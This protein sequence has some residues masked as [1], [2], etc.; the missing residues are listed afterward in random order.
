VAACDAEVGC[1][2]LLMACRTRRQWTVPSTVAS[3]VRPYAPVVTVTTWLTR[4][5]FTPV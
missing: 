3:T 4:W 1:G 2:L 5:R